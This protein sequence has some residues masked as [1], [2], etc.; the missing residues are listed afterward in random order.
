MDKRFSRAEKASAQW[1]RGLTADFNN[2]TKELP[3]AVSTGTVNA[4]PPN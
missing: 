2:A 1:R 4:W 3:R